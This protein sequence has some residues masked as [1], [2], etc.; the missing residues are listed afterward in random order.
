MQ[1][2]CHVVSALKQKP[3]SV[4]IPYKLSDELSGIWHLKL[5]MFYEA[6]IITL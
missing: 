4:E 2:F 5:K 1:K 6:L 3:E